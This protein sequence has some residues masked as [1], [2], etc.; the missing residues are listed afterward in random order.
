MS[1]RRAKT[2][3]L[4]VLNV[5]MLATCVAWKA[6]ELRGVEPLPSSAPESLA[7]EAFSLTREAFQT[8]AI[9][10]KPLFDPTRSRRQQ[11]PEEPV[12]ATHPVRPP[13]LLGIIRVGGAIGAIIEDPASGVRRYV[14]PGDSFEDWQV[15]EI[16]TKTVRLRCSSQEAEISLAVATEVP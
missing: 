9:L 5:V 14:R 8:G 2:R 15:L 7:N 3:T 13:A 4:V 12:E 10:E 1:A 11:S 6:I 16:G